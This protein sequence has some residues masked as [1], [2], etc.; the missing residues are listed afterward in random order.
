MQVVLREAR[1]PR[2]LTR[3]PTTAALEQDILAGP[4]SMVVTAGE[5]GSGNQ[6]CWRK[7]MGVNWTRTK[8]YWKTL[9]AVWRRGTVITALLL[10]CRSLAVSNV[11]G[12][13]RLPIMSAVKHHVKLDDGRILLAKTAVFMFTTQGHHWFTR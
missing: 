4:R 1:A 3:A 6:R 5:T 8:D 9:T 12:K 13:V 11:A 10:S 7:F 2:P